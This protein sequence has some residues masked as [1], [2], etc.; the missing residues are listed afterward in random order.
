MGESIWMKAPLT[1]GARDVLAESLR[2][3]GREWVTA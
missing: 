3:Y 1:G 2:S